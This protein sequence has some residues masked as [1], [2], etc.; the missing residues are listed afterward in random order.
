[1]ARRRGNGEG[2]ITRR[3]DGLYMA[4]YWVETPKGPK[5]KTIYGKKREEVADKLARALAE[6]ADGIVYD[7]ENLTVGEYLDSW[8]KGSVRGSVRQSTFDRY[9]IAVRVHIKPALGRLKLKKLTSAHLAGFYQDRLAA[10]FAP[11]SVNKLHVTL[12]KALEQAVKWHMV[13]RNV[14]EAVKAPRPA[15]ARDADC[16]RP[17]RRADCS[18]RRAATSSKPCTYSRSTPG[19]GRGSCLP[20]SGKTWTWRTPSSA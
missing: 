8:L 17:R 6:R 10:G 18:K 11:A 4:R 19:C 13:P 20:S 15:P 5:R 12:H 3:K 7:D 14:A 2:S 9:E 1:M 16:S